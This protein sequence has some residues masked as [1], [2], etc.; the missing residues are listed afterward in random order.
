LRPEVGGET[1]VL[2]LE[3]CRS[4][5][6]RFRE[7]L[8][9]QG[10]DLAVLSNYRNVYYFSGHLREVELPQFLVVGPMG[11]AVLITDTRPTQSAA[12]EVI[13]YEA[14]S[15]DWPIS[16]RGISQKAAQALKDV[17][18]T[19]GAPVS[20]LGLERDRLSALSTEVIAGCFPTAEQVD[21]GLVVYKLRKRKDPDEIRLVADCVKTIEAG[22]AIARQTIRPGATELDVFKEVHGEI[23]RHAGYNL[24][25]DADFA[26]GVRAIKGGGTPLRH[27]I[28]PGDLYI[29]DI[30]PSL[31]GY[32]GDLCRTFAASPP[33]D[34]Q[35]TAWEIARNA[36]QLAEEVIRPGVRARD[37]WKRLRDYIDSFE[38][39]GSFW[40]H[41]G[42]GLGLDPQE[43]PWIIPGTDHVFEVGDVIA[44]EP[45]CYAEVLQGGVRL[46]R[47]YVV[48]EDGLE[49]LSQF[50]L[51]L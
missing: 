30:Y 3:G 17:L 48:R 45:A 36:L 7:E 4:R 44:V 20:R 13:S 8:E 33:T 15:I 43:P 50:P 9:K 25:F 19:A 49:N 34:L 12:D 21:V 29:I 37:V 28:L 27:E 39:R 40:H 31:H 38:F 46:E 11:R 47:N 42:H 22:Y 35:T 18:T 41:A 51:E 14:Y 26:C 1:V 2:T 32:H 24:K 5:L 10:I 23:V 6:A 16:F